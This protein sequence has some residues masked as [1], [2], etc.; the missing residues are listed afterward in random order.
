MIESREGHMNDNILNQ[1]NRQKRERLSTG[2]ADSR[3]SEWQVGAQILVNVL[4]VLLVTR[5]YSCH[6]VM[7]PGLLRIIEL[8]PLVYIGIDGSLSHH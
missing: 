1:T 4:N 2:S 6:T 7:P 3:E 8:K 5:R